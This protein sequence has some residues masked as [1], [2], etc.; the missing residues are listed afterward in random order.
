MIIREDF[1]SQEGLK[2]WEETLMS[3]NNIETE[4]PPQRNDF[5]F[6]SP[7]LS[8]TAP[9]GVHEVGFE[10]CEELTALQSIKSS[11]NGT[12][13]FLRRCAKRL[14]GQSSVSASRGQ[15]GLVDKETD[16]QD[17]TQPLHIHCLIHQQALCCKVIN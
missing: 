9:Q 15:L 11:D 5:F 7:K 14:T 12:R 1:S 3:V 4:K 10:I 13:N 17:H 8:F 6:S 2:T 16:E